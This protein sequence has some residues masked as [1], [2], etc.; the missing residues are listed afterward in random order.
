MLVK[1]RTHG[2]SPSSCGEGQGQ[3]G[4]PQEQVGRGTENWQFPPATPQ[5]VL[6]A[7]AREQAKEEFKATAEQTVSVRQQ[8]AVWIPLD[9]VKIL[10]TG[11]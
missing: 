3:L 9:L 1:V 6:F 10:L 4:S 2:L 7:A 11:L 8:A 5:T